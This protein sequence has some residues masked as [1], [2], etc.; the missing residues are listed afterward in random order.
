[1]TPGNPSSGLDPG[2]FRFEPIRPVQD[3]GVPP[4]NGNCPSG[5]HIREWIGLVAQR[6][7]LGLTKEEAYRRAW[8]SLVDRNPFPA[9][10]GRVCPHPCESECN[11]TAKDGAVSVNELERF[12]GDYAIERGWP[13]VRMTTATRSESVAVVG[14]G[15]AGLSFAYQMARRGYLVT[16]FDRREQAGGMLRYGIPDYRL[17]PAVLDAE[18]ARIMD[19]GVEL[20]LGSAVGEHPTLDE[21]RRGFDILFVGIGAQIGRRM[22]IPGEDGAGVWA[23]TEYLDRLNRGERVDTGRHVV[24]VGGGNTAIDAARS[25]RRRDAAVVLLYRR[26]RAEM[27]AIGHEIDEAIEEGVEIVYL[28]A[29]SEILRDQT[30]TIRKVLVQRMRLGEADASGRRRPVPI[31]GD[32]FDIAASAVIVAVSQEPDWTA[33]DGLKRDGGWMRT[34][35]DGLLDANTYAGGDVRGL[36]T[37]AQAIGHGRAA[38]ETAHARQDGTAY[39]GNGAKRHGTDLSRVKLDLYEGAKR[40]APERLP[41]PDRLADPL[42]TVTDTIDEEAFLAEASRCLSCES[43]FGCRHCVTYCNGGGFVE[44]ADPMP[45]MYFR[46]DLSVCEGCGKCIEVCPCGYLASES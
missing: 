6:S 24:V 12:I 15:P 46:M 21:L 29:P 31:E 41:V 28:A 18:I 10:M 26:T 23:G 20:R 1:M 36:G 14:A 34:A 11:R 2:G 25:A 7:K 43:C 42:R 39:P 32:T 3:A 45:G 27:P 33:L 13:L 44:V 16:V 30:G 40:A 22:G 19:L 5:T 4:C 38:A 17:P 9:V 35:A 8:E 37:A